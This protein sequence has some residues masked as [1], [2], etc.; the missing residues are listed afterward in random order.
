VLSI[1][2]LIMTSSGTECIYHQRPC[3]SLWLHFHL[4]IAP[5]KYVAIWTSV[6]AKGI[7]YARHIVV[8]RVYI[9]C[10][11]LFFFPRTSSIVR[12]FQNQKID[13][14]CS[15]GLLCTYLVPSKQTQSCAMS[16]SLAPFK[17]FGTVDIDMG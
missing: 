7:Q 12:L 16:V 10:Q 1:F 11:L 4:V 5:S 2:T 14:L 17:K 8:Y 15:C 6:P 9:C 13:S 3:Y